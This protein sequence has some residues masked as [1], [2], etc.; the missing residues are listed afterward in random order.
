MLFSGDWEDKLGMGSIASTEKILQFS[1][2]I[3]DIMLCFGIVH[4]LWHLI[5]TKANIA[6]WLVFLEAKY[7][8]RVSNWSISVL[9]SLLSCHK[10]GLLIRK[11]K[12]SYIL[13]IQKVLLS[14]WGTIEMRSNC[15]AYCVCVCS[16]IKDVS[17]TT[18]RLDSY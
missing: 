1:P 9:A 16:G 3:K 14:K 5:N 12:N 2:R 11:G 17:K 18:V 6:S 8:F 15:H 10:N 4:H 13:E 7:T